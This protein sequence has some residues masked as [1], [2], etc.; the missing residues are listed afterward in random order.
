[1]SRLAD[2]A[3]YFGAVADGVES[4]Q[5]EIAALRQQLA[6]KETQRQNLM[7]AYQRQGDSAQVIIT[8][9]RQ[10]LAD[11]TAER[12]AYMRDYGKEQDRKREVAKKLAEVRAELEAERQRRWEG[13]R[14]SSAE[15]AASQKQVDVLL[16]VVREAN[17][18]ID[19]T[20]SD[21]LGRNCEW[22][23]ARYADSLSPM[24]SKALAATDG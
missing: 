16:D 11:M 7:T 20:Y 14:I 24:L 15:L 17:K 1:M 2:E 22:L 5:E 19:Q 8:E 10:Q 18:Y 13:N 6:E 12:D 3:A 23:A 21:N 9:L 4:Q